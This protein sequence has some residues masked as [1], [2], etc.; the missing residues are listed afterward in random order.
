MLSTKDDATQCMLLHGFNESEETETGESPLKLNHF[1]WDK[2]CTL[3]LSCIPEDR[4][5]FAQTD[6]IKQNKFIMQ[7]CFINAYQNKSSLFL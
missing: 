1:K 7:V 5:R 6:L 2:M 4:G 3:F